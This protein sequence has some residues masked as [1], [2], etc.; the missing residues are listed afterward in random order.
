MSQTLKDQLLGLGFKDNPKKQNAQQPKVHTAKP[1]HK[2][3]NAP[4]QPLSKSNEEID[5]AKAFALRQKEEQRTREQ[6][7]REKQELARLRKLAKEQVA[8]LLTGQMLNT[9]EA[10][11]VRHFPYAGK[12]K[13]VY[14]TSEQLS[15]LNAGELAV[16]QHM[17]KFCIVPTAIA[18]Q[19]QSLIPSLLALH[20][21][22]TEQVMSE[23]YAD[24]KFEVPDDL[25]W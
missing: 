11:I 14:V 13:R 20:C 24:P 16:V 22:G 23:E 18:L 12:I 19:V 3:P 1:T 10:E 21:D 17:G 25:L 5:L 8:Q 9:Q 15:A 7:E 2:K 4:T 6:A